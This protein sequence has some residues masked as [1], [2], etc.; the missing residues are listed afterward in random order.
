MTTMGLTRQEA[1]PA[2]TGGRAGDTLDA[3]HAAHHDEP[4]RQPPGP[5]AEDRLRA[6]IER[7]PSCLTE[8]TANGRVLAMNAAHAALRGVHGVGQP[9]HDFVALTDRER[10][11]EF[12]RQVS[13]GE[14]GSLEYLMVL[15]GARPRDVV[16]DAVPIERPSDHGTVVLMVTRDLTELKELEEQLRQPSEAD[17]QAFA[18][19]EEQL[20]HES[21]DHKQ[22]CAQLEAR[23]Q[24]AADREGK[25]MAERDEERR[26][27]GHA[28]GRARTQ[29]LELQAL[30]SQG[31]ARDP[32][33][34]GAA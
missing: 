34:L 20:R 29:L 33:L 27:V 19:L 17:T 14:S 23:L 32:A 22:A 16:S 5:G 6:I 12:I 18:Q 26:R 31:A 7:Q 11:V 9:Y 2:D 1:E 4:D 8:V 30:R 10:V 28:L 15:P 3:L 25:F 24:A 21:E 13:Q